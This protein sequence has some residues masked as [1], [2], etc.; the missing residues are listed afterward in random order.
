M[1]MKWKLKCNVRYHEKGRDINL[2]TEVAIID[3]KSHKH[4]N[5]NEEKVEKRERKKKI[6]EKQS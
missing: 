5:A 3:Y 4:K 2:I 1:T 6:I